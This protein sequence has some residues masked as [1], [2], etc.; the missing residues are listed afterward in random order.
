MSARS[1]RRRDR[2]ES[3]PL[4]LNALH[5]G[6]WPSP[7]VRDGG[8]G[9]ASVFRHDVYERVGKPRQ[10]AASRAAVIG[11]E[12]PH[13]RPFADPLDGGYE[14]G[15]KLVAESRQALIVPIDRSPGLDTGGQVE[16][17]SPHVRRAA[18]RRARTVSQSSSSAVPASIS[19]TRLRTSSLQAATASASEASRLW[20]SCRAMRA[21]SS[22][23]SARASSRTR[24]AS[25]MGSFYRV[26]PGPTTSTDRHRGRLPSPP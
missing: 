3:R 6:P 24:A 13:Q 8:H 11:A 14:L 23:L 21:R 5:P 9:D 19:S 7:R 25:A 15:A 1:V 10:G 26:S 18:S 12:W 17:D 2:G 4:P 22:A 16:P 20:I